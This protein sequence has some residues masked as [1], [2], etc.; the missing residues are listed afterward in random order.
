MSL[1]SIHLF[2]KFCVRCNDQVVDGFDVR[3][4]Q[5]LFCYLLLYRA[6]LQSR[7]TLANLWDGKSTVQ[8]KK[9]L[10]Q[11]LWQLQTALDSHTESGSHVLLV[12]PE[13]VQLNGEADLW[14]DVAVF[15]QAFALVKGVPGE[16]LEAQSV[17]AVR[18]AVELYRGDLL[19]GWF[20]DWCLYERERLQNMYLAMLDKL[21]GYCEAYQEYESGL[22]YG[23]SILRYDRARERTH[24]RLMRLQYLAGDRAAALRQYDRCVVALDEELSVPPATRTVALYEQIRADRLGSLPP[25]A[26][27]LAAEVQLSPHLEGLRRLEQIQTGLSNIRRQLQQLQQ[28]LQMV[29]Q[30]FNG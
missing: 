30:L 10:R 7:E 29:E 4:L 21:M 8:S 12:D 1:L 2:G 6:R 19:D 5:E 14:L 15:E 27:Q 16:Q 9:S 17:Q 28:D 24:Q 13:W 22:V 20:Q 23:A 11:V 3:K 25:A 18:S 26:P